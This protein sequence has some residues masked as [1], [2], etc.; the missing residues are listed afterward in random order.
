MVVYLNESSMFRAIFRKWYELDL[1]I[2]FKNFLDSLTAKQTHQCQHKSN[3]ISCN[4]QKKTFSSFIHYPHNVKW[5]QTII[6]YKLNKYKTKMMWL[7]L[8]NTI[9]YNVKWFNTKVNAN[10]K[11][12]CWL[13]TMLKAFHRRPPTTIPIDNNWMHR[14]YL[15]LT[16]NTIHDHLLQ[17]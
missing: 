5:S 8:S 11:V 3:R 17:K 13:W 6:D 7:C 15:L 2:Q 14:I 1:S 16:V 12:N 4:K 9:P 10:K